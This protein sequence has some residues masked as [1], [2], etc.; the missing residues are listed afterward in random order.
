MSLL[1]L[2][3]HGE[4]DGAGLMVGRLD[5]PLSQNGEAQAVEWGRLLARIPFS[6]VWSSPLRRAVQSAEL[7]LARNRGGIRVPELLEGLREIS[8][9]CWE[10]KSKE[11]IR[12]HYPA[13]WEQ[14]GRD[15][16]GTAPPG[17]E[18]FS[19]LSRRVLPV[20]E[21][22]CRKASSHAYSLAVAH[23]AVNRV[24][25]AGIGNASLDSLRD[26]PQ[27]PAA[28]NIIEL[29]SSGRARLL[30]QKFLK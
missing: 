18:S 28:L 15:M 2:F 10:G 19:D 9:G 30:E 11:W 13:E 5:I 26:I 7:I 3:R 24:F 12:E 21:E 27:P 17:G 20:F 23:Q 4:A 1:Y 25:L 29:A 22:L 8:L 16:A 14:R 6:A